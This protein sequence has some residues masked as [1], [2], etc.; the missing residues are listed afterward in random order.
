MRA[1][2]F[3]IAILVLPLLMQSLPAAA[4]EVKYYPCRQESIRM[5]WH[6]RRTARSDTPVSEP[7]PLAY[8]SPI[9]AVPRR[10]ACLDWRRSPAG[11]ET[12]R[13]GKPL[14]EAPL[15]AC[16]SKDRAPEQTPFSRGWSATGDVR[17]Y[18]AR[19]P[20]QRH[21]QVMRTFR[22]LQG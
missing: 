18:R 16:R 17:A 1:T 8:L 15:A 19:V 9:E 5:T 7:F 2:H 21:R 20:V 11:I 14:G 13:Y 22:G 3:A 4:T 6:P 10:S 12:S